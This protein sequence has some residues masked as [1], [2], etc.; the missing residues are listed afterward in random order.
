MLDINL[1]RKDLPTA[2]ARLETRKS[3]QTFLNVEAFQALEAE[4]KAGIWTESVNA[5]RNKK[6]APPKAAQEEN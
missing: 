6:A 2:I 4:R 5:K 1:L 3:P